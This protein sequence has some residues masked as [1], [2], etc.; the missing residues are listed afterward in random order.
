MKIRPAVLSDSAKITEIYNH[1]IK[2]SEATFEVDPIDAAEMEMRMAGVIDGRYPFLVAQDGGEIA[3]YA[4][5]HQYKARAAYKRS[6]EAS[7]YIRPENARRGIGQALYESL[8]AELN[9]QNFHAVIAGISLPN[10]AS[11]KLHEKFGMTKVAHFHEVGRKF[12][13][14]IDVG[15]WELILRK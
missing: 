11:V 13:R 9:K 14:W 1:Y 10:E 15:Y 12:D 2:T 5:G 4:Y 6:V 7:V 3:G 8:F